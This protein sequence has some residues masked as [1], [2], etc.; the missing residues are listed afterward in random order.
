MEQYLIQVFSV[1]VNIILL[2]IFQRYTKKQ[3]DASK[4]QE[5][6]EKGVRS[7]LRDRIVQSCAKYSKQGNV[8]IEE[9]DNVTNMYTAYKDLGGNGA[10]KN[11]YE[12][13]LNLPTI[14]IYGTTLMRG[15]DRS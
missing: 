6:L 2:W 11:I 1:I 9:L 12:R 8:P 14:D 7:L 13:F 15:D 10:T 3:S 5:A 4:K